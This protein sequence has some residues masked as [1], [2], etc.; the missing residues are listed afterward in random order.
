M[1]LSVKLRVDH[2]KRKACVDAV[3]AAETALAYEEEQKQ[4]RELIAAGAKPFKPIPD[5]IQQW[6]LQYLVPQERF[7]MLILYGPS[8]T[9]KSRLARHLFGEQDTLVIDVQHAAHPDLRP[10]VRHKHKAILLD[11]V[12]SPSFVIANKKSE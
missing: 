9:G 6:Q 10:Y 11:E 12:S 1:R 3:I 8:C 5:A 7:K 2:E 4:A